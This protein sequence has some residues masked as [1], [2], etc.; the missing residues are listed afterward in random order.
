MKKVTGLNSLCAPSSL[1][2]LL[3]L[4][5]FPS[6]S[7]LDSCRFSCTCCFSPIFL[8]QP[9]GPLHRTSPLPSSPSPSSTVCK[10]A[11]HKQ[12]LAFRLAAACPPTSRVR[13]WW[14]HKALFH[15][16]A[17]EGGGTCGSVWQAAPE[18]VCKRQTPCQESHYPSR[19]TAWSSPGKDA[20]QTATPETACRHPG[21]AGDASTGLEGTAGTSGLL[22]PPRAAQ[23]GQG[24]VLGECG[25][26]TQ[27]PQ[28]F[29]HWSEQAGRGKS[30]A[31]ADTQTG[32]SP[33]VKLP[34]QSLCLDLKNF[35]VAK[36]CSAELLCREHSYWQPDWVHRGVN[37]RLQ[38]EFHL[39]FNAPLILL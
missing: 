13:L 35:L 11:W 30:S 26:R 14:L 29:V 21:A 3:R 6:A 10:A 19:F 12:G 32:R 20:L 2:R 25:R 1:S 38:P 33:S 18:G 8:L 16:G 17:A 39:P 28:R 5:L 36:S 4:R 22:R 37:V 7:S 34:A 23:G 24:R 31:Q 15:F 27:N 9:H